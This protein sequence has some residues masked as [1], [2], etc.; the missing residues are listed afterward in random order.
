MSVFDFA[1][2]MEEDGKHYYEKLAET[3]SLAGLKTVFTRL[4]ADEQ[5]H[6]ETIQQLKTSGSPPAMQA[7][8]I[9]EETK[10]IFEELPQQA[11]TLKRVDADL[12][13][14][15]H[16]MKIE[17]DSFRFYE[18]AADKE[19]DPATSSLLLQIAAEEH[20]HFNILENIFQFVNAPN[21]YLAWAE[22]SNLGE[23]KQFGRNVDE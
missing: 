23:F 19:Q 12:A 11:Q 17:A 7:S 16:A 15:Q 10:N 20:K 14:Y 22:F 2:K 8:T 9:L 6:F 3:T 18:E 1:M 4:A 5:K 21:Q 13:A